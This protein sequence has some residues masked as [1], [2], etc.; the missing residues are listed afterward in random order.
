MTATSHV[1][2]DNLAPRWP[3]T[4]PPE[5][6]FVLRCM[7]CSDRYVLAVP[8][9]VA[10]VAVVCKQ[11]AAEHRRCGPRLGEA[12]RRLLCLLRRRAGSVS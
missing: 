2:W 9:S 7:H 4:L 1:V 8:C 3:L 12:R 6:Q 10:M 11:Y 5:Q